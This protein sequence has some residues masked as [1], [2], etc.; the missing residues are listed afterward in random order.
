V[1][2]WRHGSAERYEF[3][4]DFRSYKAGTRIELKNLSNPNNR[5]FDNTNKIM[6]FDVVDDALDKSDP[7]NRW[8]WQLHQRNARLCPEE[9][10][11]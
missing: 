8:G 3:L 11:V 1:T 9:R 5:D 4:I 6:V 2:E 7:H 10:L